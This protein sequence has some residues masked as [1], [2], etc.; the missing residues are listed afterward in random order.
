MSIMTEGFNAPES[1][2]E[3]AKRMSDAY[4]M[5]YQAEFDSKPHDWPANEHL[6]DAYEM[7]VAK[8]RAEVSMERMRHG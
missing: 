7:G 1:F 5:G 2:V 3:I 8:C 6:R 4:E